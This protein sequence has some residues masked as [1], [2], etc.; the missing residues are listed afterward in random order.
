[1]SRFNGDVKYNVTLFGGL[2]DFFYGLK[3]NEDG[4]QKTLADLQFFVKDKDGNVL[5]KDEELTFNINKEFVSEC[6]D[7]K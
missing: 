4:T 7:N 6:F 3:Y 1:V 2:G 5:P